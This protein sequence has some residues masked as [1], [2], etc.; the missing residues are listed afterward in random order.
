M[1]PLV[2]HTKGCSRSSVDSPGARTL[3]FVAFQPFSSHEFRALIARTPFCAILLPLSQ[4][5]GVC[6]PCVAKTCAVRPFFFARV[7]GEL[8]SR[9]PKAGH[10]TVNGEIVLWQSCFSN[11][12]LVKGNFEAL[13]CL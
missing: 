9:S 8:W 10:N 6:P 2:Y 5:I 3:V 13:N 4:K 11:R 7:V 12:A 1:C